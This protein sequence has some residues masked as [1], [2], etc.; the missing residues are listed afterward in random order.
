MSIALKLYG[1]SS[2]ISKKHQ[3]NQ[4]QLIHKLAEPFHPYIKNNTE[5]DFIYTFED[6]SQFII[7]QSKTVQV[8]LF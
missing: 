1:L 2:D 4:C 8:K 6:K 7:T 3:L 5:G